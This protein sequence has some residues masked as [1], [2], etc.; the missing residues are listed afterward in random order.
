LEA[1]L[2][3]VNLFRLVFDLYFGTDIGPLEARSYYTWQSEPFHYFDVTVPDQPR[4]HVPAPQS[5]FP[6]SG[7]RP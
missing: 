5:G 1:D 3:P 4:E 7:G 2:S 6:A